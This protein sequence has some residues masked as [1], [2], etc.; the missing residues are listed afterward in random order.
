MSFREILN[1]VSKIRTYGMALKDNVNALIK[2]A[3]T[4]KNAEEN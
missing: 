4:D 1:E 2:V 3:Y